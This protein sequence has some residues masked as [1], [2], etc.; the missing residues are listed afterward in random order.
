MKLVCCGDGVRMI[1]RNR[2][3]LFL[4][5]LGVYRARL[6]ST[7]KK[8]LICESPPS[9][10]QFVPLMKARLE[11]KKERKKSLVIYR[12][13]FCSNK[14]TSRDRPLYWLRPNECIAQQ[15]TSVVSRIDC[16][17][18]PLR[19]DGWEAPFRTSRER[20]APLHSASPHRKAM[21]AM[22]G[23]RGDD[24]IVPIDQRYINLSAVDGQQS[25]R[26]ATDLGHK[27]E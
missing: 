24:L 5:E 20:P 7:I 9:K 13:P 11:P 14:P 18:K 10:R 3:Q 4:G 19:S 21:H 17:S 25:P 22:I 8:S 12:W 27:D 26:C 23:R 16:N 1:P 6:R 2:A 15:R